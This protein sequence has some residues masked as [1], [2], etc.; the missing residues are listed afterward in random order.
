MSEVVKPVC[1]LCGEE[2]EESEGKDLSEF[3]EGEGN[4]AHYSCLAEA[5]VN[6]FEGAHKKR[7]IFSVRTNWGF[8]VLIG[9]FAAF[10]IYWF[11]IKPR[12]GA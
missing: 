7:S 10:I 3:I 6:E 9:G 4:W 12:I 5:A 8:W 11:L 1:F 2:G